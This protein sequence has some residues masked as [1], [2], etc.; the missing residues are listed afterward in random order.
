MN[1]TEA[2]NIAV[3]PDFAIGAGCVST[4]SK[5]PLGDGAEGKPSLKSQ[6]IRGS[7][8]SVLSLGVSQSLRLGSNIILARLLF[9][10]VFGLSTLAMSVSK[11]LNMFTDIGVGPNIIQNSRGDD[12]RFL[13][14][15]WTV[16]VI[17]ALGLSLILAIVAFPVARAYGQPQLFLV[18][19]ALAAGA[20]LN[21]VAS[22]SI[23]TPVRTVPRLAKTPRRR[24]WRTS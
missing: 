18:L 17:R 13:N 2:G 1:P 11:G 19:L 16:Q 5:A 6:A 4:A 15:A 9:P 24:W 21:G 7:I 23:F 3:P 8:W 14:T 10:E 22:T 20:L 12:P